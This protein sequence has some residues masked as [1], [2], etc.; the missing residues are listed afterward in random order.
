M[1]EICRQINELL[2][3]KI[4]KYQE[5]VD[6]LNQEKESLIASD[7]Q[8]IWKHSEKKQTIVKHIEQ[9]RKQIFTILLTHHISHDM[10]VK[11]FDAGKVRDLLQSYTGERIHGTYITLKLLKEQVRVMAKSNQDFV[12]HFLDV[13]NHV[14]DHVKYFPAQ[15]NLYTQNAVKAKN[16]IPHN[17]YLHKKV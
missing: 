14:I 5:L 16:T 13:L 9:L 7:I 11:T 15:H 4:L 10:N 3:E 8:S 17:L 6:V 12:E 2:N 1:N